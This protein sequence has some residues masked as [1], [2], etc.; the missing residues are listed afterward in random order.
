MDALLRLPLRLLRPIGFG[1]LGAILA[2]LALFVVYLQ[3]QSDLSIWHETELDAELGMDG[4]AASFAE[5][6]DL[7]SR[8]FSQLQEQIIERVG[9]TEQ[10]RINRYNRGSL[11]DPDR[12]SPNWNHTF[13]LDRETPRFGVLLLHGMSDSPYSLRRLGEKLHGEGAHVIG[14]RLPGHGTAPSGLVTVRWQ[15]MAGA[16]DLALEHL[17][18]TLGS[19]P[20]YVVGYSTGGALAVEYA[21]RTIDHSNL[22]KIQGIVLISAAIG[23]TPAAVLAVWQG[24]LGHFL[25]LE[26]L[27]WTDIQPEYDPF[28]YSSF[29]VNAGD[30]V[31]RL[32]VQIASR[33]DALAQNGGL[34]RFPPILA[35][36]SVVDATVS[37]PAL[38]QGLFNKLPTDHNELVLFDINRT[39]ELESIL[40]GDP[41]SGLRSLVDD[42]HR[43][44]ATTVLTNATDESA[45]VV[46]Q[47]RD[48]GGEEVREVPTRMSWPGG[49]YSLS[50]LALPIPPDDPL[51]GN[52]E[53]PRSETIQLGR[54]ELRGE[55]GV[56]QIPASAMLR[57]RWNPFF[58]YLE[59]RVLE[60]VG[61]STPP[62]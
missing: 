15:D 20:I 7:E 17:R 51:Y 30:Q 9:E 22:P 19:V 57:L 2:L 29:A 56:L 55:R 34:E 26:K 23:V 61:R 50:H 59:E 10:S 6:L 42:S 14:L 32:T 27:A 60:F 38:V 37:A 40:N 39:S 4:R 46:L 33:L 53:S 48:R 47:R 11:S 36:Q 44:Y 28:K 41:A 31:H 18:R 49:I 43:P 5:Y 16:S 58:S 12:W 25:G 21:L 52:V 35:F 45:N 3:G 13:E 62:S 1:M 8:V 54:I 24:R